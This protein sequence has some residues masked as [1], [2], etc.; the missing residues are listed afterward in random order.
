MKTSILN[1]KNKKDYFQLVK[2]EYSNSEVV[3]FYTKV[4]LFPAEEKIFDTYFQ[5]GTKL[6]DIGCGAGRTT[7]A[8][9]QKGFEI[10]GIDL[11]PEMI[12]SARKQAEKLQLQIDF[13]VE[14]AVEMHYEVCMT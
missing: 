8:L 2:E 4:G 9:V 5:P 1:L 7:L 10:V 6:L 13:R 12:D 3:E 11:I 14:N